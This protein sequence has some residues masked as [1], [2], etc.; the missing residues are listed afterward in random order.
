M[1]AAL[2][3]AHVVDAA[4]L[5][6][7][8]VFDGDDSFNHVRR[9]VFVGDDAALGAA[10]VFAQRGDEL[11]LQLVGAQRDAVFRGDLLHHTIGGG[12][13]GA[14]GVVVALRAGLDEDGVAAQL[15]AAHQRVDVVAGAA[16]RGTNG[17]GLKMLA[18]PHFL[19]GRIDLR[20]AGEERAG[21]EPVVD[22]LLVVVILQR[23]HRREE[24]N[25]DEH[26]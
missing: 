23:K 2:D 11:R 26:E 25:A 20:D 1:H 6:E 7:A 14:V 4:M 15:V 24:H 17:G 18:R 12:D 9:N 8:M 5:E 10:L 13:G 22:D 21:L 19:R 3:G 16:Q